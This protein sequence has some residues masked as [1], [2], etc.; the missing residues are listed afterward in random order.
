VQGEEIG[1][2][3]ARMEMA[4]RLKASGMPHQEIAE[5]TDLSLEDI[6]QL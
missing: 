5:L 4:K 6:E 2:A 3:K 1:M